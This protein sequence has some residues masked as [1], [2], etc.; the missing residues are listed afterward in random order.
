MGGKGGG[1]WGNR[2]QMERNGDSLTDQDGK[3]GNIL[4]SGRKLGQNGRKMGQ[5]THFCQSH[6]PHFSRGHRPSVPLYKLV[7]K[8]PVEKWG[9]DVRF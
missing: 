1:K 7:S 8:Y 4:H 5:N 3:C 6:F 2:G 9:H